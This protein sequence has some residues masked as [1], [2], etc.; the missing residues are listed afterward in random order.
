MLFRRHKTAGS[1]INTWFK[2]FEVG[3]E[4]AQVIRDLHLSGLDVRPRYSWN[5]AR[6]GLPV[7]IDHD[8]I[9]G[10]NINLMD[11]PAT[12]HLRGVPYEYEAA[13]ID[14]GAIPHSVEALPTDRMVLKLAI[15]APW[16]TVVNCVRPWINDEIDPSYSSELAPGEEHLVKL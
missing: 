11:E 12:I 13:L 6:T 7:H 10:L 5:L 15:R 3:E 1:E 14:V 9:V 4:T 16:Q 2:L 8:R